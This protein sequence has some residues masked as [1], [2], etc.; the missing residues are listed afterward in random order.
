MNISRCIDVWNELEISEPKWVISILYVIGLNSLR[1]GG[2]Q[3]SLNEKRILFFKNWFRYSKKHKII[4]EKSWI[5]LKNKTLF[6]RVENKMK[7]NYKLQVKNLIIFDWHSI[8]YLKI[9][10]NSK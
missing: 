6:F 9:H 7:T 3:V 5:T 1:L 4:I 10:F 2:L 8:Q